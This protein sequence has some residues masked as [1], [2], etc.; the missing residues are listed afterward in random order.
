MFTCTYKWI[1]FESSISILKTFGIWMHFAW[2]YRRELY[3]MKQRRFYKAVFVFLLLDI[4][5]FNGGLFKVFGA[6][7][8]DRLEGTK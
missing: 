8:F 7:M 4:R 2:I 5:L 3:A 1:V 6:G